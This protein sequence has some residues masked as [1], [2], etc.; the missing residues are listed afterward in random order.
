[1]LDVATE[2]V[3]DRIEEG[4]SWK[5]DRRRCRT[6]ATDCERFGAPP[7]LPP[8]KEIEIKMGKL[9]KKGLC[10]RHEDATEKEHGEQDRKRTGKR[11]TKSQ[12]RRRKWKLTAKDKSETGNEGI[13]KKVVARKSGK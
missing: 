4:S 11:V 7:P 9:Q 12:S 5:K 10:G 3:N 8:P 13:A 1:M 6:T 2:E